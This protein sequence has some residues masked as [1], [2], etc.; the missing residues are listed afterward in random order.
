MVNGVPPLDQGNTAWGTPMGTRGGGPS[1]SSAS[2]VA[3]ASTDVE[4]AE[5]GGLLAPSLTPAVIEPT[6]EQAPAFDIPAAQ[7]VAVATVRPSLGG[8]VSA[9]QSAVH[10]LS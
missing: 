7:A 2:A 1:R 9:D 10:F 4:V 5:R 6:S 3:A 8:T